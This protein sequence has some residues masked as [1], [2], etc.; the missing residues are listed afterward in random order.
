MDTQRHMH[1]R[2]NRNTC[3]FCQAFND[4][5][6][7]LELIIFLRYSCEPSTFL[8]LNRLRVTIMNLQFGSVQSQMKLG[9]SITLISEGPE[10]YLCLDVI[11][12]AA[13]L[14]IQILQ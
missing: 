12:C 9:I 14:I 11:Y 6:L 4:Q 7:F 13:G 2:E 3:T 5:K 1:R 8:F 10:Q